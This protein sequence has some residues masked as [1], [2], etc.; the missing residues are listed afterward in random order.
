MVSKNGLKIMYSLFTLYSIYQIYISMTTIAI[1]NFIHNDNNFKYEIMY[2]NT[3]F[4]N[5]FC[6]D[7]TCYNININDIPLEMTEMEVFEYY[8]NVNFNMT[9]SQ[10]NKYVIKF[11][12][13]KSIYQDKD[14][15]RFINNIVC[16]NVFMAFV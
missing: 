12:K 5:S 8:F 15:E 1:S 9:N 13:T 2:N 16:F 11:M 4:E 14:I 10:F 6:M 7:N 3:Y